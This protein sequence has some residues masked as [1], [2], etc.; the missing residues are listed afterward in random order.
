MQ[1]YQFKKEKEWLSNTVVHVSF[2][3]SQSYSTNSYN[4]YNALKLIF[5]ALFA[6]QTQYLT[7]IA[8]VNYRKPLYNISFVFLDMV[9]LMI[10]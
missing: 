1:E 5:G 9:Y 3:R 2:Q 7:I 6:L 8:E 4:T 10:V